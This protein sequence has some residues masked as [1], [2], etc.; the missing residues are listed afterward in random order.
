MFFSLSIGFRFP[1]FLRSCAP[2]RRIRDDAPLPFFAKQ[3]KNISFSFS[4]FVGWLVGLFCFFL[5]YCVTGIIVS[6]KCNVQFFLFIPLHRILFLGEGGGNRSF[7]F[8]R[9]WCAAFL[10]FWNIKS[11]PYGST[12]I[13]ARDQSQT[14]SPA[15]KKN[16]T[17]PNK[18]KQMML[19]RVET[20]Q[21]RIRNQK[22]KNTHT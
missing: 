20:V 13:I 9:P 19:L 17:K 4:L 16:Q 11:V 1:F 15:E 22:K 3:K 7:F 14:K 21:V 18:T 12:T 2:S 6:F 5:P 10:L 8:V